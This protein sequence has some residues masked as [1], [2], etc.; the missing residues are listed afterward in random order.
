MRPRNRGDD[1]FRH[2]TPAKLSGCRRI[3]LVA[4]SQGA[5][6]ACVSAKPGG[7][8]PPEKNAD[9]GQKASVHFLLLSLADLGDSRRGAGTLA[10]S[11]GTHADVFCRRGKQGSRRVSTRQAEARATTLH[12]RSRHSIL[13]GSIGATS[14]NGPDGRLFGYHWDC[15][16]SRPRESSVAT[17]R[18]PHARS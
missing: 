16:R 8:P 4:N 3:G 10:C 13:R 7:A 9:G 18:T 17:G 6:S 2:C 15:N 1:T 12:L 11:V 5:K 14:L